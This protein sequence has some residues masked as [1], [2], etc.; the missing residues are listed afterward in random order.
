LCEFIEA[1]A[2]VLCCLDDLPQ[3][4]VADVVQIVEYG[5]EAIPDNPA[6]R[7]AQRKALHK[8]IPIKDLPDGTSG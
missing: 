5:T 2:L 8:H 7:E 6:L 3:F 1:L 4:L